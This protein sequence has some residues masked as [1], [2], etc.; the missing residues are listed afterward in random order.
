MKRLPG[1]VDAI[2]PRGSSSRWFLVAAALLLTGCGGSP[3]T[4]S[5]LAPAAHG[6]AE[7]E[8]VSVPSL[9]PGPPMGAVYFLVARTT[10]GYVMA[11]ASAAVVYTYA[12]DRPGEPAT[13]TGSCASGWRPVRGGEI[14]LVS[15]ADDFP[16]EFGAIDGQITYKG[17]PLYTK[18]G[19][20][21]YS[22]QSGGR[23]RAI[24]L[25]ARDILG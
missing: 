4:V 23:W 18:A 15:P 17:L 25:P 20:P 24:P 5:G 14:G 11:E 10:R 7:P 9:G 3:L 22:N 1:P 21:P 12:G 13:C 2:R 8:S 16:D 19:A 6:S